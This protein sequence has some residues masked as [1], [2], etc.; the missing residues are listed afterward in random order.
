MYQDVIV[1]YVQW[2]RTVAFIPCFWASWKHQVD[3]CKMEDAGLKALIQL[4][5]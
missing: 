2:E 5:L 4:G 1:L 3:H